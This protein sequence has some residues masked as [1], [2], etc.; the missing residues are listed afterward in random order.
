[1]KK[2]TKLPVHLDDIATVTECWT[3]NRL[4][5]IKT[6]P[7]YKDWIASHYNLCVN[8]RYNFYFGDVSMYPPAYHDEILRRK[9]I[10]LLD[11]SPENIIQKLKE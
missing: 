11:F 10:R 5:I 8:S 1:M 6:S 2:S 9:P 3:F 7:Y 4:A